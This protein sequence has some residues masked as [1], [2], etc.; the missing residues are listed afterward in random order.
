MNAS[1]Y[2]DMIAQATCGGLSETEGWV[3]VVR[4]PCVGDETCEQI[5]ESD[6]LKAQDTN[7]I[8]TTYVINRM[9]IELES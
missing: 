6:E 9:K 2:A 8:A 7:A 5:C 4:R 1:Y 3:F